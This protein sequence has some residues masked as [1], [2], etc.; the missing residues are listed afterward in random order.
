MLG[1]QATVKQGNWDS[2][3][4]YA[5]TRI[6][7][8]VV[9]DICSKNIWPH[10]FSVGPEYFGVWKEND[11]WRDFDFGLLLSCFLLCMIKSD[12]CYWVKLA[13]GLNSIF[14]FKTFQQNHEHTSYWGA[15]WL[16]IQQAHTLSAQQVQHTHT[17]HTGCGEG[18]PLKAKGS[19]STW[20][21][22]ILADDC[23]WTLT[24]STTEAFQQF[25]N[26]SRERLNCLLYFAL[27]CRANKERCPTSSFYNSRFFLITQHKPFKQKLSIISPYQWL[28]KYR[29]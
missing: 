22:E 17:R 13:A 28:K 20:R 27:T 29:K 11:I 14:L 4:G 6:I 5:T 24:P 21:T 26:K 10:W 19:P 25:S 15:F 8:K 2:R 18:Y 1:A 7:T 9:H 16:Q 23:L 3:L 12:S